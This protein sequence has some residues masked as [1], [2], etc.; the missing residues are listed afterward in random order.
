MSMQVDT[1]RA[2]DRQGSVNLSQRG[3]AGK[4]GG[5]EAG[6]SLLSVLSLLGLHTDGHFLHRQ[7]RDLALLSNLVEEVAESTHRPCASTLFSFLNHGCL[8]LGLE[9]TPLLLPATGLTKRPPA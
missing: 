7:A 6:R 4:K 2:G 3:H 1:A 8:E 5:E 9:A